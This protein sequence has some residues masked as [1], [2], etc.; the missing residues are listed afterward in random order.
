V[1]KGDRSG[2]NASR[3]NRAVIIA[4]AI[5]FIDEHGLPGLTMRRLGDR[6]EVEAMAL[7]HYVPSREALL[8]GIVEVIIDEMRDDPDVPDAPADG[9]QEFVVKLAHGIR[10][11]ALAHPSSFPLVAS[12]PAEAPWLRPPLRSLFWVETFLDGLRAE[13]FGKEAAADAYRAFTSFLL[14]HLL[15]EVSVRGA[16]IGPL[17]VVDDGEEAGPEELAEYPNVRELRSQLSVDRSQ[18]EFEE[19]LEHLMER[20]TLMRDEDGA[21]GP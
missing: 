12:R 7:Y 17:D 13:G 11:V 3:L 6:L 18:A 15:L 19:S 9:W 1:A 16:D 8:D 21:F 10:R 4:A 20:M 14:G 2:G 5:D